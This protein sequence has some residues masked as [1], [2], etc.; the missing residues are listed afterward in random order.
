MTHAGSHHHDP[1]SAPPPAQPHFSATEWDALQAD[2]LRAA[3][4]VVGLM[5]AIFSIG[6]ILYLGVCLVIIS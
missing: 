4:A 3:M 5:T 6:L 2:D 1:H